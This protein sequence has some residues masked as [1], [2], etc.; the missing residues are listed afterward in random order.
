[1]Q[2][3]ALKINDLAEIVCSGTH[4][5]LFH[6]TSRPRGGTVFL[7]QDRRKGSERLIRTSNIEKKGRG[8]GGVTADA[9][10][11]LRMT[12][13]SPSDTNLQENKLESNAAKCF[14]L[15]DDSGAELRSRSAAPAAAQARQ[16]NGGTFEVRACT[17]AFQPQVDPAQVKARSA[18][19]WAETL[20]STS[21][22]STLGNVHCRSSVS[23]YCIIRIYVYIYTCIYCISVYIFFT[24]VISIPNTDREQDRPG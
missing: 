3:V 9:H 23:I 22:T 17:N 24:T 15:S 1:M 16:R 13:A 18:P 7:T 20:R 11:R 4:F 14:L 12:S 2:Q 8:G 21:K 5:P 19:N 10:K 6:Q